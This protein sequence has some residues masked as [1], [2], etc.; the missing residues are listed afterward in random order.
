MDLVLIGG[1]QVRPKIIDK[2]LTFRIGC[3]IFEL[4]AGR[5]PFRKRGEKV[6]REEV[7]S[8]VKN[9]EEKYTEEFTAEY[10]RDHAKK[11]SQSFFLSKYLFSP[12]QVHKAKESNG[13]NHGPNHQKPGGL[14]RLKPFSLEDEEQGRLNGKDLCQ[15]VY[16]LLEK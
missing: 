12:T 15:K 9:D 10:A 16:F 14:M 8:R 2:K 11:V 4:I 13:T 5:G 6:K 1:V 7:D 3:I